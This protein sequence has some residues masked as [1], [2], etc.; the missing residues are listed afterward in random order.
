M[1]RRLPECLRVVRAEDADLAYMME[2]EEGGIETLALDVHRGY[3]RSVESMPLSS[4]GWSPSGERLLL[5]AC[6][7]ARDDGTLA[8]LSPFWAPP[9]GLAGAVDWVGLPSGDGALLAIP[10]PTGRVQELLAPDTLEPGGGSDVIWSDDD[11]LAWSRTSERQAGGEGRWR[12]T[13]YARPVLGGVATRSWIVSDDVRDAYFQM[14]DWVPG[15]RLILAVRGSLGDFLDGRGLSLVTL[16]ADNGEV[17][18]LEMSMLPTREA[19]AWHPRQT[20]V[21][22]LAE[23]ESRYLYET[24]RI[25]VV[26]VLTGER[27]Y[28]GGAD[29][30]AFEPT[31][32]P[33]GSRLAFAAVPMWSA[34]EVDGEARL[35]G[36]AI[37]LAAE[38]D[39]EPRR[40][41][42]P[43]AGAFDG[44]PQWAG[45]G[46]E[47]VYARQHDG[48]TDVRLMKIDGR[49]DELVASGLGAPTC[50]D[51]GCDW[52]R[53]LVFNRRPGMVPRG[54]ELELAAVGR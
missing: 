4:A 48:Y 14:L 39:E 8:T 40:L 42:E 43:G 24:G 2:S 29:L 3:G 46:S 28:V 21:L 54:I 36:R 5:G 19:Y 45:D 20:G 44:W 31:W 16:H 11:W 26:D 25:T 53:L 30:A 38:S 47:L 15:T 41:T 18:E 50:Y 34:S 10:F 13:V 52:R 49:R 32:S 27:R 1:H 9:R 12:Q 37:Y 7:F 33:D 51:G 17:G 6:A 35:E 22:A 23:G